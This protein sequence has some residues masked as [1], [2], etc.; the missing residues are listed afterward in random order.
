[1]SNYYGKGRSNYIRVIDKEKAKLFARIYGVA[2][3]EKENYVCFLA[4]GEDGDVNSVFTPETEEEVAILEIIMREE[5]TA[6]VIMDEEQELPG[7]PETIASILQPGQVFIWIHVGNEKSRYINGYSLAI[8]SK[9]EKVSIS[10]DSIYK[11]AEHLGSE[12]T[13]AQY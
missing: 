6:P 7:F 2:I 12:I 9:F 1:M 8:N 11:Q 5:G 3:V 13:E 10:L 4:N